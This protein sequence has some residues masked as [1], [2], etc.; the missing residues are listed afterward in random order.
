MSYRI[1]R[2][3]VAALLLA[4]CGTEKN[5]SDN[6]L[7]NA[8]TI[9]L[10]RHAEKADDGTSDPGLT[11]LGQVRAQRLAA[12]LAPAR[13][14]AVY[15]T[16]YRRN[17][18]TAEPLADQEALDIQ[19][20]D[21]HDPDFIAGLAGKHPGGTILVVGHSNTVP[22]MVNTLT[23]TDQYGQLAE[24]EYDKLFVVTVIDGAGRA[25]VFSY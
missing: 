12:M 20:Y 11:P 13:V 10:V 23:G 1:T 14:S 22:A 2:F 15:S 5:I 17:R 9:I 4:G 16:P 8:T 6:D 25:M 19:E 18:L 24:M 3:L 21:A 7:R